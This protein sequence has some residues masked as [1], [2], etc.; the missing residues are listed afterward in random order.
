MKL[1]RKILFIINPISGIGKKNSVQKLVQKHL[2]HTCFNAEFIF[3]EYRGHGAKIAQDNKSQFDAIVAVGGDGS[4]NEI[5]GAIIN[6]NC[7][8]GILPSGSGNGLARHLNIPLKIKDAIDRIN[9]FNPIQIDTGS[10][11]QKIFLGTCGFGFDA[12]IAQQFDG[13]GKRGFLSYVKLV[14]REYKK[15][16]PNVFTIKG[17]GIDLNKEVILCSIANSSQFGNGFTISPNSD[18]QDGI[19]ELVFLKKFE[20]VKTPGIALKFFTK[21]I[22]KSRYFFT[23]EFKDEISIYTENPIYFHVDGEPFLGENEFHIK[24]HSKSLIIL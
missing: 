4:V 14:M 19:F 8:L 3:T 5:G 9:K 20:L 15:F 22:E 18:I 17:K 7:A 6:S 1:T 21:S 12:H 11:N 2:N 16:K 23:K 24:I 10:V 13:F